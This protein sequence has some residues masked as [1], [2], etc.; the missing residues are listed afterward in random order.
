MVL[1]QNE[2]CHVDDTAGAGA[3]FCNEPPVP[4]FFK[5]DGPLAGLEVRSTIDPARLLLLAAAF[6]AS[7]RLILVERSVPQASQ[8]RK[9]AGLCRVQTSQAQTSSS[10]AS[11]AKGGFV[12]TGTEGALERDPLVLVCGV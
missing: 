8:V 10:V 3:P 2:H 4:L 6:V 5:S 11:G 9:E 12:E 1:P 7:S